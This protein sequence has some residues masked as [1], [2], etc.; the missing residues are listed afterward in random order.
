[1][2]L[3]KFNLKKALNGAKVVTRG[4][5]EVTQLTKFQGLGILRT[6]VGVLGGCMK[7]WCSNGTFRGGEEH[8]LDLFLAVEPK[9]IWVNVYKHQDGPFYLGNSYN[10]KEEA[11]INQ[12][13][14]YIKTIEITEEI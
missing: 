11:I 9:S 7:T 5:L 14:G 10:T 3:E 1:M 12:N 2:K 4:G 8:I 13:D 6:L